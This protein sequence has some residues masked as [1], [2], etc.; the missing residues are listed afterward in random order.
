MYVGTYIYIFFK[1]HRD[2]FASKFSNVTNINNGIYQLQAEMH[3]LKEITDVPPA[4][5]LKFL[6]IS[7]TLTRSKVKSKI[8]SARRF[9]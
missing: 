7:F 8:T 6:N 3:F 5:S 2:S 1:A 4:K 9:L